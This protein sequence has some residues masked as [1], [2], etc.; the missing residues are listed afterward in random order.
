MNNLDQHYLIIQNFGIG[1]STLNKVVWEEM[2]G[3]LWPILL[4]CDRQSLFDLPPTTMQDL[5][6]LPV[7]TPIQ[8]SKD[9]T[10]GAMPTHINLDISMWVSR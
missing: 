10:Q 1:Q 8:N 9:L 7:L 5:F 4:Y 6:D 3:A 2:L